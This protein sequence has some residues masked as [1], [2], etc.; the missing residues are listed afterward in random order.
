MMVWIA[1]QA[2]ANSSGVKSDASKSST[3]F[4]HFALMSL[5]QASPVV[6]GL[7]LFSLVTAASSALAAASLL[8]LVRKFSIL[9]RSSVLRG[10]APAILSSLSG[11]PAQLVGAAAKPNSAIKASVAASE[12][13]AR[14]ETQSRVCLRDDVGFIQR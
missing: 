10:I 13:V 4:G 8:R 12:A 14:R 7:S 6:G 9:S 1:K 3:A 2:L 5:P 11:M